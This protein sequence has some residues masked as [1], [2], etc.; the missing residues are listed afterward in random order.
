MQGD[1]S[2]PG[3]ATEMKSLVTLTLYWPGDWTTIARTGPLNNSGF[4]QDE[5]RGNRS[6]ML[7]A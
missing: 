2:R 7:V 1:D 6:W 3:G 5:P 4:R